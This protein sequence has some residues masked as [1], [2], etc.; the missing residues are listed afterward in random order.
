MPKRYEY[1]TVDVFTDRPFAGNPVA[2]R[3]RAQGLTPDQ[4]QRIA[5][6][7][8]YSESTFVLPPE[9]PANTARVRIFTPRYE[10]PFAGHPNLGTAHVVALLGERR[11]ERPLR[12]V[13]FEEAAGLVPVEIMRDAE[14][15]AAGAILTAPQPLSLGKEVPPAVVAACDGLEPEEVVTSHH[16]PVFASVGLPFVIA[17]VAEDALGRVKTD[18]GAFTRAAEQFP[19]PSLRFSVHLYARTGGG[20]GRPDLRARMFAPLGGVPEDP[21]TGSANGALAGLLAALAPER[22]AE[23]AFEIDQGVEMGRPSRLSV[24]VE[25]RGGEVG[26]ARVGGRCVVMME[27]GLAV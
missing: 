5:S 6:E 19:S 17:E 11:E 27:G 13:V 4:M 24:R 23:F 16:E 18:I 1:L 25:K 10:V 21:A 26:R 2:V 8:N 9:D 14:G 15:R 20:T 3:P 7:F 22:E 12:S